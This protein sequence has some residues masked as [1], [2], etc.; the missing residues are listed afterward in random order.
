MIL[1][2]IINADDIFYKPENKKISENSFKT[3]CITDP[4]EYIRN[5]EYSKACKNIQTYERGKNE[6]I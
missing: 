4:L 3:A 5:D 1:Y 2:T 6:Y